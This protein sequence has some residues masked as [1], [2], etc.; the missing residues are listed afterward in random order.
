LQSWF[1]HREGRP[2]EPLF[3]IGT[4]AVL[5]RSIRWL[6]QLLG[7]Q[8]EHMR[9]LMRVLCLLMS[10]YLMLLIRLMLMN[11]AYIAAA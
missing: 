2:T 10:I 1:N 8:P 3:K 6:A 11:P 7:M 4:I 5:D 9:G